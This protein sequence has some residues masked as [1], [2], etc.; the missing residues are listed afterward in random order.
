MRV[1]WG[2][3]VLKTVVVVIGN[4]VV[5]VVEVVSV[6]VVELVV[7]EIVVAIELKL[8]TF[9]A[10]LLLSDWMGCDSMAVT[11]LFS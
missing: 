5:I 7:G 11:W 2:L 10:R 1:I 6:V 3:V 9:D 4:S 8:V